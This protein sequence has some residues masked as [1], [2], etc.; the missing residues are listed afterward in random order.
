MR[1]PLL[2]LALLVAAG[3]GS[4]SSTPPTWSPSPPATSE[5]APLRGE[6]YVR[7]IIHAHSVYSHDACD[8]NPWPDGPNLEC[9]G[10]IRAAMCAAGEDWFMLTDHN[11][12][13][14]SEDDFTK[15]LLHDAAAG[16][17]LVLKAGAPIANRVACGDGRTVLLMA[18]HEDSIMPIGMEGHIAGDAQARSDFYGRRDAEAVGRYRD[19]LGALVLQNH[20]EERT[21][22]DLAALGLDGV[23]V[24]NAHAALLPGARKDFLHV[25]PSGALDGVLPF[26]DFH[27]DTWKTSPEPDLS[28]LGFLEDFAVYNATWDAL[29]AQGR[30]L[31]VLGTDVHQN[32][33]PFILK[34]GERG[35]SYRRMM[36]WYSNWVLLAPGELT[37]DALKAAMRQGRM[38]GVFEVLG[39]PAGLDFH[40]ETAGAIAEVGDEVALGAG[41]KLVAVAPTVLG[42]SAAQ[43]Q[44]EVAL[45][46]KCNGAEVATG[47]D[48]LEYTPTAAGFCRLDVTIVPHHLT[49][50]LGATPEPFVKT[51]PWV[52]VNPIYVK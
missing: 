4:S 10:Q 22:E 33:Y 1:P 6:R 49:P 52:K 31:G 47:T 35:D 21:V 42:L 41:P 20:T 29:L 19:E 34:D 5:L 8:G 15:L 16:D 18:G 43:A 7:G 39:T 2:A 32:T 11:S 27:E 37:P 50:Y 25:D 13:L 46:L 26:F 28:L 44:P 17:E 12:S 36:R 3:C 23:E 30:M 14:S 38:A 40:A 9:W 45:S 48:R 24:F 51:Y